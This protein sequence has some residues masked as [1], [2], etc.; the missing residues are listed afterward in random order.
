[1]RRG[2]QTSEPKSRRRQQ[3]PV[4]IPASAAS[5]VLSN[6]RWQ[7]FDC[8]SVVPPASPSRFALCGS[9][10]NDKPFTDRLGI[11]N[12]ESAFNLA[13]IESGQ[14][15]HY[16]CHGSV[17]HFDLLCFLLLMKLPGAIGVIFCFFG[18]GA[19]KKHNSSSLS[20]CLRFTRTGT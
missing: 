15:C 19:W 2:L 4:A 7:N 1:M 16:G 17:D 14:Q 20:I 10:C 5:A 3:A 11:I 8:A 12:H 18:A 13:T 6:R 9:W